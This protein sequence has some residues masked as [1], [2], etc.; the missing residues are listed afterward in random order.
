MILWLRRNLFSSL[1]NSLLTLLACFLLYLFLPPL[2]YRFVRHPL[3]LGFITAFWASPTMTVGHLVFAV[4]TTAYIL[5]A[6]QLE[7][8]DL[9]DIHGE[10]YEA[11]RKSTSMILP[12]PKKKGE[13]P[14]VE[15]S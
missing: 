4:G 15:S 14:T 2:F 12:L 8:R 5:I 13:S 6:I 1:L 9:V 3:Y 10:E 11:Y 7:E